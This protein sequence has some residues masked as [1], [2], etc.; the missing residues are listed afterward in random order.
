MSAVPPRARLALRLQ[1]DNVVLELSQA[2][3][4]DTLLRHPDLLHQYRKY[5]GMTG[6]PGRLVI[7]DPY[8][9]AS[10]LEDTNR[11]PNSSAGTNARRPHPPEEAPDAANTGNCESRPRLLLDR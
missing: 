1:P 9:V 10:V 4:R 2:E 11:R 5:T 8:L 6:A 3:A 7:V